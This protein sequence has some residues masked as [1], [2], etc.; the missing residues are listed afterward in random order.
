MNEI[1]VGLVGY[2]MA[3]R[4]F[5]APVIQWI[6]QLNLRKIV[7]RHG[8]ESQKL[9]PTVEVVPDIAALLQDDK[10]DLVVIA[11]PNASHF[12]LAKQSLLAGKHVVV[13]KPFTVTSLQA[14]QLIELAQKENK[15]LSVH[16]NRRWDGDF[17]TVKKLLESNLLGRLV[18]YE[19]HF[20]R[21]RNRQ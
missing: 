16:Q 11:I 5:H 7:E 14:Q 3:S 13:E 2:G 9:Y 4:V 10:I 8:N 6:P 19:S 21:F 18:E 12:D 15:V 1:N 17:L 20:D